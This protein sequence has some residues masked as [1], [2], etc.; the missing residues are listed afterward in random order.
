MKDFLSDTNN[1]IPYP[2]PIPQQKDPYGLISLSNILTPADM[3]EVVAKVAK[4]HPKATG[5]RCCMC[6]DTCTGNPRIV[7]QQL[8]NP[9]WVHG[10]RRN[11]ESLQEC[12]DRAA[13]TANSVQ[14]NSGSGQQTCNRFPEADIPCACGRPFTHPNNPIE[15]NIPPG[16][17]PWSEYELGELVRCQS[18]ADDNIAAGG[19]ENW[20]SQ[21]SGCM[22]ESHD[23]Y[24]KLLE[25]DIACNNAIE[26]YNQAIKTCRGQFGPPP[27]TEW[28]M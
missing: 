25:D 7:P 9:W 3:A 2:G 26:V 4:V 18:E 23:I 14:E 24:L 15:P 5:A 11:N 20:D 10:P 28:E 12:F 17:K 13:K 19:T 6:E 1:W 22:R 16:H 8:P 27:G 21:V